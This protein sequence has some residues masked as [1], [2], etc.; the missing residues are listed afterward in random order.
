M[1][2]Y[3]KHMHIIPHACIIF[4]QCIAFCHD[5]TLHNTTQDRQSVHTCRSTFCTDVPSVTFTQRYVP[6][7]RN[8]CPVQYEDI[9][10]TVLV[11]LWV[12]HDVLSLWL[13][14]SGVSLYCCQY[15]SP[16]GRVVIPLLSGNLN[17]MLSLKITCY[18]LGNKTS[19]FISNRKKYRHNKNVYLKRLIRII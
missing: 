4:S 7:L 18:Q 9:L 17:D 19:G 14:K 12:S 8:S 3:V 15:G 13:K 2:T 11:Y 16:D 6:Y 1:Y 10:R 5:G